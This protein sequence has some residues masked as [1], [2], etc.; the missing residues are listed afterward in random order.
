MRI[1]P[2]R[3]LLA[4][5]MVGGWLLAGPG[6]AASRPL[7][8]EV[9]EMV[10][11]E[12]TSVGIA[13]PMGR[14]VVLLREPDTQRVLP[15]FLGPLQFVA[16]LRGWQGR[17]PPRP[18]M[19]ELFGDLVTAAGGRLTRVYLDDVQDRSFLGMIE[20]R[21]PGQRPPVR[22]DSRAGDAIT[23]ALRAEAMILVAPQVMAFA[24]PVAPGVP[25][26]DGDAEGPWATVP[27]TPLMSDTATRRGADHE[28]AGRGSP[29]RG[30]G[31]AR[32]G[33]RDRKNP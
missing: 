27:D 33:S 7:G 26:P 29:G 1:R 32:C 8:A 22:L 2:V 17:R 13:L 10:E 23:L 9:D 30:A 20:L 21:L 28:V 14:P 12:V 18:D 4:C 24:H 15:V 5:L 16:V 19:P 3:G 31:T 11:V 6:A 25:D